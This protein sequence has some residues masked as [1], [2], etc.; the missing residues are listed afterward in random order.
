MSSK[1]TA[2]CRYFASGGTCFYGNE[3][4]FI[5][6]TP[7]RISNKQQQQQHGPPHQP[8]PPHSQQQHSQHHSSPHQQPNQGS[9]NDSLLSEEVLFTGYDLPAESK[10]SSYICPVQTTR[11]PMR[12][13]SVVS[14]VPH[15]AMGYR[16]DASIVNSNAGFLRP[17]QATRMPKEAPLATSLSNLSMQDVNAQ[18]FVPVSS[19]GS[20]SSL[21]NVSSQPMTHSLSAPIGAFSKSGPAGHLLRDRDSP[22]N[23]PVIARRSYIRNPS[24]LTVNGGE[25]A[26]PTGMYQ[27]SLGGT[28]YFY[29]PAGGNGDENGGESTAL[30]VTP[31][32]AVA[33]MT[34][35]ATGGLATASGVPI[36]SAPEMIP[37]AF[38]MFPGPPAHVEHMKPK[39]NAPSFFMSDEL[40]LELLSRAALLNSRVN[41]EFFPDLPQHIDAYTNICPLETQVNK[42]H[43][44]GYVTSVY[45]A[46]NVKTGLVYCLRRIHGFRLS[47][48]KTI[49]EII[50]HWKKI[51]HSN[52]VQLRE[53]FTTKAFG[54][55]S[56]VFVYDFFAG[57]QTMK[58]V[59]FNGLGASGAGNGSGA[60]GA[61]GG[62]N[63]TPATHNGMGQ[64]QAKNRVGGRGLQQH[65]DGSLRQGHG[66]LPESLIWT[67]VVQLS[68]ALR[69]VHAANLAIRCL[70]PSKVLLSSAGKSRLRL[71]C[72]AI[73]DVI[74][75]DSAQ[76]GGGAGNQ[77]TAAMVHC[78]QKED[79]AHLGRLILC[80]ACNSSSAY[81]F[82]E[83]SMELVTK[84]YSSDL[85]NLLVLLLSMPPRVSS[86]ND[87]MPMIGA[88]FYTQLD[89]AQM[90]GDVLEAELAKE[91][92]S[93][94]LFRLLVKLG[95]I[96]ERPELN[97]DTTWSETG[98]RYMLKLFR[99]FLFHQCTKEGQPWLDMAHVVQCLNKLDAGVEDKICL[100]SRDEQNVLVVSYAELKRCIE[101]AFREIYDKMQ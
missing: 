48:T 27:E 91:V 15:S 71:N 85:R 90:R 99:D 58:Q 44:Y 75:L 93:S 86:I 51:Q 60:S 10:L 9:N 89:A 26:T 65:P 12:A 19:R 53:L 35:A 24:P 61:A 14:D 21:N 56:V 41:A 54:D 6:G 32:T 13:A 68:S 84:N 78:Y 39:A 16:A 77:R 96:N 22:D 88:R 5:H 47:S 17:L 92:D 18:E 38:H 82:V 11:S 79:L 64:Q 50:D 25:Y 81:Q 20:S 49:I 36:A 33:E 62:Y 28:T 23:S 3:C 97:I 42:S 66:L 94:R 4:Q 2:V 87:V 31:D 45:R 69:T 40:R 72:A 100:V 57:A 83:S 29:Q 7:D 59:Y 70:D 73:V 74:T 76:A 1:S 43:C 30:G 55:N 63:T 98:D 8:P 34:T 67:Y 37:P 46:T 80:L 52:L 101:S 95:A